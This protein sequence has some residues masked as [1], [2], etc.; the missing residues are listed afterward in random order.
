LLTT[1]EI[2]LINA[3]AAAAQSSQELL[4]V[5]GYKTRTGN[6]KRSM[7]KLLAEGLLAMTIPGKPNSRNQRY[8]A[9][10]K[11]QKLLQSLKQKRERS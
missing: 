9:T 10:E 3:C 8:I 5:A 11:G 4:S 7:E 6:F 2:G 1:I